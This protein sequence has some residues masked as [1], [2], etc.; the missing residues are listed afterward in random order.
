[1]DLKREIK[2]LFG[3]VFFFAFFYF[4]PVPERILQGLKEGA[5]L[6]SWYAKEHVLF[7][8][9]PAFFIAGA[10]STF[11]SKE[12]VLKY[13][14][15]DS[16][17]VFAF[18][19]A[20]I[21]GTVLAVCSCTV[22]PLFAG[23]YL[24]GAGIGPATTFLYS[25]PAINVL[26]I[27]LSAKVLGLNIGI[28]RA[29]GSISMGILIGVLMHFI[30]RESEKKRLSGFQGFHAK[31]GLSL[32]KATL[33]LATLVAILLIATSKL[34]F[35][36]LLLYLLYLL[37]LYEMK[38]FFGVALKGLIISSLLVILSYFAT[39]YK[40]IPF[41]LGVISVSYLANKSGGILTEW[42]DNSYI[43]AKQIFPL[44]F[45]GVFV[46]GFFLGGVEGEGY[47]PKRFIE[48][49]LG[50]TGFITHFLSAVI[51]ALM[52]FATLTEV[53]IIQ[54]LMAQ[55]VKAGP[56]LSMLLAGPAVSLPSI[57]VLRAIMGTKRTLTYVLLVVLISALYGYIYQIIFG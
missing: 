43:L 44:L 48:G 38:L 56:A 52:Y 39:P 22:L 26:A 8:L 19:V 16:S 23:L 27:V 46:S 7:C 17:K 53:P 3:F 12:S 33:F 34:S 1:M 4:F 50:G 41:I 57:L 18:L 40:E 5:L 51:T 49:L 15:P 11:I 28:A 31:K 55:G 36:W 45:L 37:L 13:L 25:G 47:I 2:Y 14:G 29:I 20:S 10:I 24:Q 6:L 35:K 21:S 30:F 54:G 9:I 42:F 32:G